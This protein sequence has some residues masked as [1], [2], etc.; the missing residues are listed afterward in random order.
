M[1]VL[2]SHCADARSI[3]ERRRLGI[4]AGCGAMAP[5]LLRALRPLRE[6]VQVRACRARRLQK[7]RTRARAAEPESLSELDRPRTDEAG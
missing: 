7:A 4:R 2:G 3:P 5:N 1:V 6:I